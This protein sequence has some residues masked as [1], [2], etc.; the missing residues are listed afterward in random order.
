MNRTAPSRWRSFCHTLVVAVGAAALTLLCFLVLPLLEA[1]TKKPAKDLMV[2]RIDSAELPVPEVVEEPPEKEKPPEDKPPELTEQAPPLD[3]SQLEVALNPGAFGS[4]FGPAAALEIQGLV[5]AGGGG[6]ESLFSLADLD[7]KPRPIHQPEPVVSALLRKKRPSAV[8]I[9]VVDR[10]GR[11]ETPIVESATDPAFE[12]AVL[13]A[14][15][16]W[17]FEP[18]KRGGEPVRFRVRQPFKVEG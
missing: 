10:N 14:V 18:G 1:I 8:V 13:T 2:T 12:S 11:V 5:G 3:L 6:V 17:K 7:Q 4:G 16:Q 15:R 9:F